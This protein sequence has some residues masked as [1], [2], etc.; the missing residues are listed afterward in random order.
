[1]ARPRAGNSRRRDLV[2]AD[3][4]ALRSRLDPTASLGT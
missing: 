1:M 3:E 4:V 2:E